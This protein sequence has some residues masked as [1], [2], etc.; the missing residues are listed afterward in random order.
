[1]YSG[2]RPTR[3]GRHARRPRARDVLPLRLAQQPIRLPRLARQPLHV[4][5]R[6]RPAHVDDR[7]SPPTP[8][9]IA[10]IAR[11]PASS[12]T[13]IPLFKRHLVHSHGKPVRHR[14]PMP[15]VL[16]GI[17]VCLPSRRAHH[18]A[19]RGYH[20]HLRTPRPIAVPEHLPP[21]RPD[22]PALGLLHRQQHPPSL[23]MIRRRQ[24]Q[25]RPVRLHRL[26]KLPELPMR[27][28]LNR[29]QL[30]PLAHHAPNLLHRRKRRA[31][32]RLVRRPHSL[33]QS[34]ERPLHHRLHR[35]MRTVRSDV[36]HPFDQ[37]R[38]V[39]PLH[40]PV[41]RQQRPVRQTQPAREHNRRRVRLRRRLPDARCRARHR[42][43]LPIPAQVI[44]R[45]G[46][47]VRQLARLR[48]ALLF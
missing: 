6:I 25:P 26:R 46:L 8:A 36:S 35:F 42:P 20:H 5:L 10:R 43:R 39:P 40:Q 18:E 16:I 33:D 1:M 47:L 27:L 17:P 45:L 44:Q 22:L 28:R 37:Q 23:G 31:R 11:A 2:S 13:R 21:R 7:S 41:L 29:S 12:S 14:H 3:A 48:Q 34:L 4:R 9:L 32:A 30:H 19:S 24:T 38:A 15:G